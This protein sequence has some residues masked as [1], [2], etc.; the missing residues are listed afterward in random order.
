MMVVL[1]TTTV[2]RLTGLHEMP[3]FDKDIRSWR[4]DSHVRRVQRRPANAAAPSYQDTQAGAHCV[5][6]TQ[7]QPYWSVKFQR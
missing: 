7:Y 5:C 2:E 6:G 3:F 1:L 4:D